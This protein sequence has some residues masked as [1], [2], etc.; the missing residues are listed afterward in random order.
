MFESIYVGLTGLNAFS[1]NLTVLGNNVANI[2]SPG[3]KGSRLEFS[4]LVYN[5]QVAGGDGTRLLTGNGVRTGETQ[6]LFKQGE[7]RQSGN[8]TD[9]AVD[10]NGFFVLRK[11][12]HTT[13]TRDGTFQ[14]DANGFLVAAGGARVASISGGSLQDFNIAALRVS[15]PNPTS[16]LHFTDNLS[17]GSTSQDVSVTVF[18]STGGSNALTVH[19]TNNNAVTPR[20][21]IVEVRDPGGAVLSTGEIRFNGD[22]SPAAGFNSHVFTFTPAAAPAQVVTLDFGTP[23][24]FSGATNFSAGATSTLKLGSQDGFGPGA[25]TS[26]SF[27]AD[28][29]LTVNYSNGKT[30][31]GPRLALAAFVSPQDLAP[32]G[33]SAFENRSGQAVT[34]GGAGEGVFG[35]LAGQTLEAANVDLGSEFGDLIITQRG[36][37]ASSQV[38]TTTNDMIQQ[39]FDIAAKR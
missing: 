38:I 34:L 37:Q 27:G 11:D 26:T 5:S 1:R 17:S 36:Y 39:L 24:G 20:S 32:A 3:F 33:G 31:S 8:A 30:A 6:V 14:L 16:V 10:G 29:V 13:Y 25:L 4:D 7:L 35:R 28:G 18:D 15:P 9:V 23:G 22:G 21:W 19:F 12:G 2:D